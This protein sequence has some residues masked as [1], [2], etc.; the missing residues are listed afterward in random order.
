MKNILKNKLISYL[1]TWVQYIIKNILYI[2][3]KNY[4]WLGVWGGGD[5]DY[6]DRGEV[7]FN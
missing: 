5:G 3:K 6:L 4:Y 2:I 7:T 1:F